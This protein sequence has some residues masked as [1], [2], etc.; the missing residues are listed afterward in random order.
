MKKHSL[1]NETLTS[2]DSSGNPTGIFDDN[3]E[4]Q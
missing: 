3:Q 2:A 1:N 4:N